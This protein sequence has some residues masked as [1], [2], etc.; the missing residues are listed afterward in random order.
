MVPTR[1]AIDDLES[2]TTPL[3]LAPGWAMDFAD[4]AVWICND[5]GISL[6]FER[7]GD[8]FAIAELLTDDRSIVG[9]LGRSG[10]RFKL[11]AMLRLVE[12][13]V[14]QFQESGPNG[15]Q[16]TLGTRFR[17][18]DEYFRKHSTASCS[19]ELINQRLRDADVCVIGIG[20]LGS[21][22]AMLLA[23]SGV[24]KVRLVDGDTVSED[25]LPRQ[26]LFP[27]ASVGRLKVDVLR[28][29]IAAHRSGARV[30]AIPRFIDSRES[31]VD[32]IRGSSFVVLC[33][34]QP[35]FLIRSWIGE[36]SL[37]ERIPYMAMAGRWVG[38]IS[39]PFQSPCHVC[40]A[41]HYRARF[42]DPGGYVSKVQR[43]PLPT[44]AAFGPGPAATAGLMSSNILHFL[45]GCG[46]EEILQR[47]FTVTRLGAVEY[48]NYVRYRDCP[49]CGRDPGQ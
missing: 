12:L 14:L 22:I 10:E 26:F 32:V 41:R 2:G 30:E 7:G 48:I 9:R 21:N 47:S 33:A 6:R 4:E 29:V 19:V 25:N 39:V 27:E 1:V 20:G 23:A 44:R 31:A 24:G 40:R 38:P 3:I 18:Q 16:S 36:A 11:S 34:D 43:E 5:E 46:Y 42:A 45:A 37:Q 17:W 35:R 49:A 15:S 28:E 8:E 13:G